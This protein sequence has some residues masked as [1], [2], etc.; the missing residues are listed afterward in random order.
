[1]AR[2]DPRARLVYETIGTYLGYALLEYRDFYEFDHLL[3]LGR[4][5][6][7]PG[8]DVITDRARAVIE[9]EDPPAATAVIVLPANAPVANTGTGD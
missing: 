9:A 7:G 2:G 1:M 8:G 4:V 5:M 6:T 3:L